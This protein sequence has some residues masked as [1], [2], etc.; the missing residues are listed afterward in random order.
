MNMEK[1]I[2]L[3]GL[4]E[5]GEILGVSVRTLYRYIDNGELKAKKIGNKWRVTHEDLKAYIDSK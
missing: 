1:E 3:Y 5:V 2:K 4:K